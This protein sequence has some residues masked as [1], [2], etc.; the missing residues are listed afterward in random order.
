MRQV[1]NHINS[2]EQ[3]RQSLDNVLAFER[4]RFNKVPV[5]S[6]EKRE[7]KSLGKKTVFNSQIYPPAF[8]V[9]EGMQMTSLSHEPYSLRKVDL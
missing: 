6:F 5:E 9:K 2:S 8:A 1:L 3:A 7:S 4:H